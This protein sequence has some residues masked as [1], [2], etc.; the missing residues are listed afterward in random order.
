MSSTA[1]RLFLHLVRKVFDDPRT[2]ACAD[3]ELLER[4]LSNRDEAA[5][6]VILRRHG[7]MVH[8]V[9]RTLLPN[10]A[11]VEDAFQAVFLILVSKAKSI[12]KAS[13]IASWLHGVAYRVARKAQTTF[14]RRLK[15]EGQLA[16]REETTK[17]DDMNWREVRELIH[18]ELGRLPDQYHEVLALC[19][20][21][22][23][24]QDKAAERLGL[25]KGTLK[26]RLERAREMLRQRLVRR[27]LGPAAIVAASA[28]P[29][30]TMAADLP[31]HLLGPAVGA[32]MAVAGGK[33][34]TGLVSANVIALHSDVIAAMFFK[35]VKI[36]LVA[37]ALVGLL[38]S[39]TYAFVVS[40]AATPPPAERDRKPIE[41]PNDGKPPPAARRMDQNGDLLPLGAVARLGTLRFR[42]ASW[43][44]KVAHLGDGE[45]LVSGSYDGTIRIWDAATGQE[46]RRFPGWGFALAPD[47]KTLASWDYQRPVILW[48]TATGKELRQFQAQQRPHC[49][50]FSP[51][52]KVLAAGGWNSDEPRQPIMLWDLATG[53]KLP[54]PA[55]LKASK[56]AIASR[57]VF[58][59][60]SKVLA[61]STDYGS[62]E[63]L[64]VATGK[65]VTP[66]RNLPEGGVYDP[67]VRLAFSPDGRLVA[68]GGEHGPVIRIWEVSSGKEKLHMIFP[69]TIV[70]RIGLN[71]LTFS[72]DGKLLASG[73][74]NGLIRVW[75]PATG[76]E[77]RVWQAH[78]KGHGRGGSDGVITLA[79]SADGKSLVSGGSDHLI[80]FWDVATGNARDPA[81]GHHGTVASVTLSLDGKKVLSTA[82][83]GAIRVWDVA[84]GK[85]ERQF[86]AH[87]ADIHSLALSPD[88]KTLVSK[89]N[90]DDQYNTLRFWDIAGG[91]EIR[92]IS[93][94][95]S[96]Y[97]PLVYS[98]DG[99]TIAIAGGGGVCLLNA[100]SGK[101][102]FRIAVKE[103]DHGAT[104]VAFS[105]DRK[106][107]AWGTMDEDGRQFLLVSEASTGKVLRTID[108]EMSGQANWGAFAP[109][110]TTL[111]FRMRERIFAWSLA[112]K[113]EPH[114]FARGAVSS[115]LSDDRKSLATG[116]GDGA[117]VI[118]EV[119]TRKERVRFSGHDSAARHKAHGGVASLA[120]SQDGRTLV[121]G[122]ADTTVLVWDVATL[123]S[124]GR[125]RPGKLTPQEFETLWRDL[126]S[127]DAARA[128]SAIG[129]L[130]ATP[131]S[132]PFI[133][134]QLWPAATPDTKPLPRWIADLNSD[135]FA[136]RNHATHEIEKLGPLAKPGLQKALAAKPST[137][138]RRRIED[139]L[140]TIERS[141]ISNELRHW[142]VL[143]ALEHANTTDARQVLDRLASEGPAGS[144]TTAEA[145]A[146][147]DRLRR[148][149]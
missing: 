120:W 3:Q 32:A 12:R 23:L 18:D 71:A 27:G 6:E 55:H 19:Y 50:A 31:S 107:F 39:G 129:A 86:L 42:H 140:Q 41:G 132:A 73:H 49:V 22:G 112:G 7:P 97:R 24:T 38:C 51:D 37:L 100:A 82:A 131:D 133:K 98:P 111:F 104:F 103:I 48:D 56:G 36:A 9:C 128:Y 134:Q 17:A 58:S 108:T 14:A 117:I 68:T 2:V 34:A 64:D 109:D 77:L 53:A 60:D 72:P 91:K 76:K 61:M 127:D 106:T 8:D 78:L 110:G 30:A 21:E 105:P 40:T 79:F 80:R 149:D 52:G 16:A 67:P 89:S 33:A 66:R 81:P 137:E 148:R 85:E 29:A 125:R 1:S 43:V 121:S 146:A 126:A 69:G 119:A 65:D 142:R 13:S 130:A 101:E 26:G 59:P 35:K 75:D 90:G 147:L 123:M 96:H 10:E 145:A 28:W 54:A 44:W 99:K 144:P 102:N 95:K 124:Q 62:V 114:E 113:Q 93:E 5:F 63:F 118:W 94:H 83:D 45:S 88:G 116:H 20:L 46:R 70:P 74:V 141:V 122:G 84:A 47:G 138:V 15:H 136:V 115:T 135:A 87:H 92:R 57:V 139:L 11:D 25:P 4:F 143:E